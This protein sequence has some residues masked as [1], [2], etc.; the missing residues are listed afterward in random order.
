MRK[1]IIKWR[2]LVHSGKTMAPEYL[3]VDNKR[4]NENYDDSES[5]DNQSKKGKNKKRK[6][7]HR[8]TNMVSSGLPGDNV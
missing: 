6:N 8:L 2:S 5:N 3:V 7:T 4:K 1:N